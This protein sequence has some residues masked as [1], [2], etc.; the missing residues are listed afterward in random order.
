MHMGRFH[1]LVLGVE[2]VMAQVKYL[3]GYWYTWQV[4]IGEKQPVDPDDQASMTA[5]N[6]RVSHLAPHLST[7]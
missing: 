5:G 2:K 1:R 6:M 4:S 7:G 3:L